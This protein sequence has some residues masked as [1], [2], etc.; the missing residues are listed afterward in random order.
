VV[1]AGKGKHV[2]ENL[3]IRDAPGGYDGIY[4]PEGSSRNRIASNTVTATA[5]T[6]WTC[7]GTRT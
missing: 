4:V 2:P 1:L 6:A 3:T 5:T 7:A